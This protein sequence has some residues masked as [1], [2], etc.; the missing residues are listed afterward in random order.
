MTTSAIWIDLRLIHMLLGAA[1]LLI[2]YFMPDYA[3]SLAF[4]Q[5]VPLNVR[6]ANNISTQIWGHFW[7]P[8]FSYPLKEQTVST[9]ALALSCS[10]IPMGLILVSTMIAFCVAHCGD[11][12][13]APA[14]NLEPNQADLPGFTKW[15]LF[16]I[17][18]RVMDGFSGLLE[19]IAFTLFVSE[20]LKLAVGQP[21]PNYRKFHIEEPL[22]AISSFPSAHS[23]LA[24]AGFTYASM[25]L[26]SDVAAPLI[27]K[28][29]MNVLVLPLLLVCTAPLC[30]ASWIAVTR[31][32]DYQHTCVDIL[33]GAVI[34][35]S[36]SVMLFCIHA[37]VPKP[38][39]IVPP[40]PVKEVEK[41]PNKV[42]LTMSKP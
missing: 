20:V 25:T 29:K 32:H 41:E 38:S 4:Q 1:F 42:L 33:A 36:S 27:K 26:W 11:P 7:N 34:G 39:F 16:R 6:V 14:E 9:S 40:E 35:L 18:V 21:R 8:A 30:V 37:S 24:F 15:P 22:D 13:T 17:G 19:S 2:A 3:G 28:P 31:V 12:R 23:S 5:R 10:L